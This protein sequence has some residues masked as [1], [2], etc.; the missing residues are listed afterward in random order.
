MD[1]FIRISCGDFLN[2]MTIYTCICL[3]APPGPTSSSRPLGLLTL[4]FAAFRRSSGSVTRAG[5]HFQIC[6]FPR[7]EESRNWGFL[8]LNINACFC[9]RAKIFKIFDIQHIYLLSTLVSAQK[10]KS[11]RERP[12]DIIRISCEDNLNSGRYQPTVVL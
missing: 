8:K 11:A 7:A 2:P 5:N 9:P 10:I 12:N 4:S 6:L 3:G 1:Y